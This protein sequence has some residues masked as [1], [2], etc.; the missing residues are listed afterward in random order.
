MVLLKD[1]GKVKF[2]EIAAHLGISKAEVPKW[3]YKLGAAEAFTGYVDWKD[4]VLYSVEARLLGEGKGCPQCGGRLEPAGK[5][6]FK[7]QYCGAKVFLKKP[8]PSG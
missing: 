8:A 3:I 6:I 1:Q 2:E 5:G 7:C 4:R